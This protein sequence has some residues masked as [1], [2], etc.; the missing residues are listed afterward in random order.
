MRDCYH[1]ENTNAIADVV[2]CEN[3]EMLITRINVPARWRGNKIGSNL[4]DTICD[5]ADAG[6]KVLIVEPVPSGGLSHSALV[7]WY[8]K[9]GFTKEN[10]FMRRLPRE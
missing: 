9:R 1:C 3:G 5:D 6:S 4:L 10:G 2:E 8:K 7:R